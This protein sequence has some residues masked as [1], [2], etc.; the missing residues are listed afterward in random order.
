[1]A[2]ASTAKSGQGWA[3]V[4]AMILAGGLGTRLRQAVADRPK[5]LAAV[6]GRP[7]L[8]YQLDRLVAA[9]LTR[10]CLCTGFLADQVEETF[11]DRYGPLAL[12]YSRESEPLGTGG[13]LRLAI[14]RV[15]T[16]LALVLNGDS[17][18]DCDLDE[19]LK[20]SRR[21]QGQSSI[22]LV[23]VAA[24]ESFGRVEWSEVD[25]SVQISSFHEKGQGG[26]G[27]INAGIYLLGREAVCSIQPHEAV[28]IEQAVFPRWAAEGSLWG[29]LTQGRFLDIGTPETYAAAAAY[30]QDTAVP[31]KDK[32]QIVSAAPRG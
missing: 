16:P 26:P 27:W 9:G 25:G 12:S 22:V 18:C 15:E 13:A 20:T 3:D 21:V 11:G 10:A 4:T 30:L 19:L 6:N 29:C 32:P 1:M 2:E 8:A 7:F 24:A 5:C 23:E 28:S 17:L 31:N 14:D